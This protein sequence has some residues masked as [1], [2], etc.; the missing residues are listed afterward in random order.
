MLQAGT[1]R[2]RIPMRSLDF[3]NLPNSSTRIMALGSTQAQTEMSTRNLAV[4]GGS[5][6]RP[7]RKVDKQPSV[8]RLS[9]KCGSLDA[10][11]PYGPPWPVTGIA[12]LFTFTLRVSRLSF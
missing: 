7:A 3:F 11:Q 5:K 8:S 1:S 4:E 9:R 10:S 2:V 6:R 12:L